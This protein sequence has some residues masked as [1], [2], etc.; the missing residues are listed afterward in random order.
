VQR[1]IRNCQ[2]SSGWSHG[3]SAFG[4]IELARW[5][6]ADCL[7]EEHLKNTEMHFQFKSTFLVR[8]PASE[9]TI[10][11]AEIRDWADERGVLGGERQTA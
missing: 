9:W 1:G 4:G 5:I 2:S 6:L 11:E 3:F 8:L 10:S 7:G